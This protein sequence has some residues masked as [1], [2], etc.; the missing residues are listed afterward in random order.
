MERKIG[1]EIM[2]SKKIYISIPITG[3]DIEQVKMHAE[4]AKKKLTAQGY[5]SITPFDVCPEE[6]HTYAYYMGRDIEALL[7]CDA[8]YMCAGWVSSKGCKAELL[9]ANVYNKEIMYERKD[10]TYL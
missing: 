9:T 3:H 10:E 4:E 7:Q 6:G 2:N 1:E 8:I 5:D